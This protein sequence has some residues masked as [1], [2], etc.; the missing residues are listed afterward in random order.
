MKNQ[1]NQYDVIIVG[2]GIV[3]LATAYKLSLEKKHK[4]LLLEKEKSFSRHQTGNNS[5]VIHS[6][7]YY[8]P[9]SEKAKNC[10]SGYTQLLNFCDQN[11]ISYDICGKIIVA[12]KSNQLD[13]LEKI[14][15]RGVKNELS[16]IKMLSKEEVLEKEPMTKL[17][18]TN[19]ISAFIHD[20]FWHPMDTLRD[21]NHLENL[22]NLGKAPWKKWK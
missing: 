18:E 13:S 15:K 14:Y 21:K 2:A 1:K 3:G 19:N 20:G 16:G 22:W 11:K 5:G 10:K 8:K 17:A 4:I 7:I 6:G 9:N 12:T